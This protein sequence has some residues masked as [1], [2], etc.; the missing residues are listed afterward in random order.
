MCHMAVGFDC[1]PFPRVSSSKK[2]APMTMKVSK[3]KHKYDSV[4]A[5]LKDMLK[6]DILKGADN[7]SLR[8]E[9]QTRREK[10]REDENRASRERERESLLFCC[11]GKWLSNQFAHHSSNSQTN[12]SNYR[13]AVQLKENVNKDDWIAMNGTHTERDILKNAEPESWPAGVTF[14]PLF[15][16]L[17]LST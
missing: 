15:S 14:S 8:Y 4:T 9:E 12:S 2:K 11:A 13:Q 6:V 3:K 7:V 1:V 10:K 5:H 17:H 16:V